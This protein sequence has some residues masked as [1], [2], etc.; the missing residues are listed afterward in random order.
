MPW[1]CQNAM[2]PMCYHKS[3]DIALRSSKDGILYSLT[4]E[5]MERVAL[6]W[7]DWKTGEID[8]WG[9]TNQALFIT[10]IFV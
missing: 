5:N 7:Q 10:Y 2:L 3:N 1:V 4:A 9:A 6:L 8:R